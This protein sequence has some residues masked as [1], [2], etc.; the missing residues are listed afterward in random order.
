MM[1]KEEFLTQEW[2]KA[3]LVMV[4]KDIC[5]RLEQCLSGVL[6]H[7]TTYSNLFGSSTETGKP[8]TESQ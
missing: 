6:T 3:L 1:L 7:S 4:A 8:V 2:L 5:P